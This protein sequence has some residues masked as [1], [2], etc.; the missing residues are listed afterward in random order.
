MIINDLQRILKNFNQYFGD[1]D[2]ANMPEKDSEEYRKLLLETANNVMFSK[3]RYSEI[4]EM[5]M[6]LFDIEELNLQSRDLMAINSLNDADRQRLSFY[7]DLKDM[8]YPL[9]RGQKIDWT[10]S[11]WQMKSSSSSLDNEELY[12]LITHEEYPCLGAAILYSLKEQ[13]WNDCEFY[14]PVARQEVADRFFYTVENVWRG[15]YKSEE[16]MRKLAAAVDECANK[17]WFI[18]NHMH[19]GKMLGF[20]YISQSLYDAFDTYIDTTYRHLQVECAKELE[21]HISENIDLSKLQKDIEMQ[22]QL[23]EVIKLTMEKHNVTSPDLNHTLNII[24]LDV[25]KTTEFESD[26][27]DEDWSDD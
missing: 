11:P 7:I 14:S 20:N 17:M 25:L 24:F 27:D 10:E 1:I 23:V 18:E 26:E 15:A 4:T 13:I 22:K 12:D 6:E 16:N 2:F 9:F 5:T 21:Q 8:C 19:V 3:G